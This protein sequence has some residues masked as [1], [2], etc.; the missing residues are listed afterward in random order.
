MVNLLLAAG[1]NVNQEH[2]V[3]FHAQR[4]GAYFQVCD[5]L[6]PAFF[7][8]V[9]VRQGNTAL[10]RACGRG[11]AALVKALIDAGAMVDV[12]AG[13]RCKVFSFL[14]GTKALRILTGRPL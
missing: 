3:S 4:T 2:H 5:D 14:R 9:C 11:N 8:C 13:P 10:F 12:L 7:F 6:S 1:A